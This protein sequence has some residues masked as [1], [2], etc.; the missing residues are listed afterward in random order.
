[1]FNKILKE[2]LAMPR[3]STDDPL[4]GYNFRV[5][6]PGL[7]STCGFKKIAGLSAERGVIEYAEG[8][9]EMTHKLP[10]RAKTGELTCEKG[11]F[12]SK[13]VENIF[14]NALKSDDR[15]TIVVALLDAKGNVMRDWKLAECWCSKWEAGEFDATSE[16]VLVETITIQYEAFLD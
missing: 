14:R 16:D 6:I 5:S 10:G 3:T 12:P 9:Y 8:G 13:Q 4:K 11:M 1:M 2:V 7:P 15:S